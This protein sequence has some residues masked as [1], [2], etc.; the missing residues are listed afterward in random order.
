MSKTI[1]VEGWPPGGD[2]KGR[3]R[4]KG[5]GKSR[6]VPGGRPPLL[7]MVAGVVAGA[8]VLLGI[9]MG[10]TGNLGVRV[11]SP[12]EVGVVVNYITGKE[13][14]VPTPGY[15]FYVPF[16][17]EVYTFDR[18]TQN[19]VMEGTKYVNQNHV[20]LLTVRASDG[21]NFRIDDLQIQYEIIP[22]DAQMLLHDSGPGENF[23][24]GWIK[25]YARSVL[26]D[27]F[28]RYSAVEVA[29]PTI[30][31]QAPEQAKTRLNEFL[32][33]HGI[34]VVLIK[35]PNPTFDEQ[36]EH[37]IESR[38]EADQEVERL[39][40]YFQQLEQERSRRLAAVQREK[41]VEMEALKGELEKIRLNA[42]RERIEVTKGADAHAI[43]RAAEGEAQRAQRL[44]EAEG[45][46][47]KYR[48]EAEGITA[49]AK[50]LE[51]RGEVVVREAI[52]Q[53]L[54]SIDFTLIP[55]NRDPSPK[56]LEHT[57]ARTANAH[58]VDEA[59]MGGNR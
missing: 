11:I 5:T 12:E 14:V 21:S 8:M 31:K 42:E 10:L 39:K 51:E 16:V 46:E 44:A 55:Y 27:E 23:K 1:D 32:E 20:P 40:E 48:K 34:R 7:V 52:I 56:R 57:D 35:T 37:A 53:K 22:G 43:Q 30:Y 41:S 29:D 2:G 49:R 59:S 25:G 9:V 6:L 13:N 15:Q 28:G 3:G 19:F 50:A 24:E 17:E 45:L 38:K 36:Y 4:G 54:A 26:R 58:L 47:E 33:P 18:R